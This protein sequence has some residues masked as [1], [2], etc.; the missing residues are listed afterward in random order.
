[1]KAWINFNLTP[2][3]NF[4]FSCDVTI[5]SDQQGSQF[6]IV[7][8]RASMARHAKQK[9]KARTIVQFH[10]AGKLFV[11]YVNYV[12]NAGSLIALPESSS[13]SGS[14]CHAQNYTPSF[15]NICLFYKF[16]MGIFQSVDSLILLRMCTPSI[17]KYFSF[18]RFQQVTTYGA[19]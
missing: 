19:K 17:P 16:Q 13:A 11:Q 8:E 14:M 3:H 10:V 5:S 9:L 18:Q 6:F 7:S 2:S 15:L 12:T 1:M 4:V